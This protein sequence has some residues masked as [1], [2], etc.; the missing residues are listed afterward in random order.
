[1]CWKCSNRIIEQS[2]ESFGFL[3]VGCKESEKVVNYS[4]AMIHC[5]ICKVNDVD[6]KQMDTP[7]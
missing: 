3:L 7:V 2:V 6:R 5:P 1:M 4:T